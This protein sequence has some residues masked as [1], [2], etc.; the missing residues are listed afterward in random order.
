MKHLA[1]LFLLSFL[2]CCSCSQQMDDEWKPNEQLP[3]VSE[4]HPVGVFFSR[5]SL[6]TFAEH[7]ITEVG[8]YVYLQDSM[9]YGKNLPLNNGDLK[10]D[11]PLGENLQ[12]F[13]VANADHLVD[14][15][16][17]SKVV[18][19]QDAHIQKPVERLV[20]IV[21]FSVIHSLLFTL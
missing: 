10:V 20:E 12:T 18:V 1:S 16:S 13:I 14:T 11:L 3:N 19:Y 6:E 7:G 15:D 9:V 21:T 8:V 2:L 17:L 5:A 4:T